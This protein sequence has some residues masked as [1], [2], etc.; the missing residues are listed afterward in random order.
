MT[1]EEMLDKMVEWMDHVND[2]WGQDYGYV[3]IQMDHP[4]WFDEETDEP[5]EEYY[6]HIFYELDW[7]P[8]I[9]E[10]AEARFDEGERLVETGETCVAGLFVDWCANWTLKYVA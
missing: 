8:Y 2:H 7:E 5:L 3:Y 10:E 9:R 1:K 6:H 4:E